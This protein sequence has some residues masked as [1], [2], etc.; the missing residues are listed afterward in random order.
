MLRYYRLKGRVVRAL[1]ARRGATL[2]RMAGPQ[3]ARDLALVRETRRLAPLL[4]QDATAFQ[5]L[6]GV[7]AARPLGH[8]MAEAGVLGGG[9]ARL[10]CEAKGDSPLYLFDVFETLRQPGGAGDGGR[11]EEVRTH[12]GT[13]YSKQAEVEKLLG[14]YT[15]VHL[16]PGVFPD[17][18]RGLEDERFS[19]VH[20]DLDLE[21]STRDALEFFHPRLVPGGIIVGDDYQDAG[22]RRAFDGY[23]SG[24]S[25]TVLVLPWGQVVVVS[26]STTPDRA[27]S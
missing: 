17:S 21:P 9:T 12:F 19:F 16:R 6:A 11:A 14:A 15:R 1:L 4:V 3:G 7:R 8:A 23:L 10:I 25:D 20:I 13:V 2:V 26:R 27:V 22:V 5:I 18:A 24:R